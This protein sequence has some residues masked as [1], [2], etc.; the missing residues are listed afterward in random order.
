MRS[1]TTALLVVLVLTLTACGDDDTSTDTTSAPTTTAADEPIAADAAALTI[2]G[3]DFGDPISIPIGTE[4]TITNDDG[5]THTWTSRDGLWD[6]GSLGGGESFSFTFTDTG[7]FEFFC[8]IH[9]SM[10][11]SITVSG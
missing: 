1:T 8:G 2:S 5:A 3:F 6:S 11:G 7:T 9:P 4:V 10:T